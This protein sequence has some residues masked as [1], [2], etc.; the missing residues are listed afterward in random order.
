MKKKS[1]KIEYRTVS[2]DKCH[3]ELIDLDIILPYFTLDETGTL[4]I[5][6]LYTF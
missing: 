5:C 3:I 1:V 6:D 4:D 2:E